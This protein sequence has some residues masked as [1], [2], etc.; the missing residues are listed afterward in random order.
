MYYT[1]VPEVGFAVYP[2]LDCPHIVQ[3]ANAAAAVDESAGAVGNAPP[4]A[5]P[6]GGLDP[7][8]ACMFCGDRRE[9]WLCLT[10]SQ[11]IRSYLRFSNSETS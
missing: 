5:V 9:N 4:L 1:V 11:V 3:V 8:A 7:H 6:A 2:K 10:C